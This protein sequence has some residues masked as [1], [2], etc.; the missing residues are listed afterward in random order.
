MQHVLYP[1]HAPNNYKGTPEE[2]ER[3]RASFQTRSMI[4]AQTMDRMLTEIQ[5]SDPSAIIF[6]YGDHGPLTSRPIKFEENKQFFVQ[7]RHGIL[8]AVINAESCEPYLTP[9]D[10]ERFQTSARIVT[11]LVQCLAGGESPFIEKVDFGAIRQ[12]PGERFEDYVY[13]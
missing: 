1:A 3:Y 6:L 11:G 12:I 4:A 9:P 13:E 2:R 7:D 5:S 8:G 10:G